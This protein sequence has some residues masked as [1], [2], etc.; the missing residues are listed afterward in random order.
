MTIKRK[1]GKVGVEDLEATH[2]KSGGSSPVNKVEESSL[3]VAPVTAALTPGV[4]SNEG[5]G[6]SRSK[7]PRLSSNIKAS[8][9][10]KVRVEKDPQIEEVYQA[11]GGE[12]VTQTELTP[13]EGV[14]DSL[15]VAL[16]DG[17]LKLRRLSDNMKDSFKKVRLERAQI[18]GD[19]TTSPTSPTE[20]SPMG[21][22]RRVSTNLRAKVGL[23][24]VPLTKR[25]RGDRTVSRA[26][27][28]KGISERTC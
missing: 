25:K 4:T 17:K 28:N 24:D 21:R 10:G 9:K 18:R 20:F 15:D 11:G 12:S 19:G 23:N 13:M 5:K 2:F 7:L 16:T 22:F 3:D 27:K 6:N 1:T 14:K 8:F 26:L